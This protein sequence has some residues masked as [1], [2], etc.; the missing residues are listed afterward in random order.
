MKNVCPCAHSRVNLLYV[1]YCVGQAA[2]IY[3]DAEKRAVH[4]CPS[5]TTGQTS[6]RVEKFTY[7]NYYLRGVTAAAEPT[8]TTTTKMEL[9]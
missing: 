7:D 6:F 3:V 2:S 4:I 8:T 9:K 5:W 1:T